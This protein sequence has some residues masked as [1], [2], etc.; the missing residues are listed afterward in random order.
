VVLPEKDESGAAGERRSG[1]CLDCKNLNRVGRL[2]CAVTHGSVL[3][4]GRDDGC[5]RYFEPKEGGQ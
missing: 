5:D 3:R 1:M 4:H 2:S